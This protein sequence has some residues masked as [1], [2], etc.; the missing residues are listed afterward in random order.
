VPTDPNWSDVTLLIGCEGGSIVDESDNAVALTM[1]GATASSTQAKFGAYSAHVP[2][3]GFGFYSS[4]IPSLIGTTGPFTVE[5]FV[6][7]PSAIT[8]T[9]RLCCQLPTGT[10]AVRLWSVS[11]I[12]SSGTKLNLHVY[13]SGGTAHIF[14]S[15][16]LTFSTGTW[17]H[18][19]MDFDG[20]KYRGYFNG[21]RVAGVT[22]AYTMPSGNSQFSVGGQYDIDNN[23]IE[24]A[25]GDELYLDE[26]RIT[27]GVARYA[28]DTTY[29]IPAAAF[30]RDLSPVVAET[31]GITPDAA[32][33]VTFID[34]ISEI[35]GVAPA[36]VVS[37]TAVITSGIGISPLPSVVFAQ[38]AV[39]SDEIDVSPVL[40]AYYGAVVLERLKVN[41]SQ[42]PNFHSNLSVNDV[43][44][45]ADR[46][47]P[48]VPVAIAEG[49]GVALTDLA[50]QVTAVIEAL[51]LQDTL[52]P[53]LIYN[54][55][56]AETLRLA[57]TLARFFGADAVET[58]GIADVMSGTASMP[59]MLSETI[60]VAE[61]ASPQMVL[62]VV[63]SDEIDVNAAQALN[64]LFKPTLAD[65]IEI[66]A[67][68]L[69][70]GGG[71][72]TWAMNTRTGAVTEYQNYAF[73]SFARVGNKYI[74]ASSSGLY[75]LLGDDDDGTDIIATIRSGFAQWSGTHL[76]SFK[77]AYLAVRGAGA[78][79]LRV[80]TADGKTYN[81]SVT[82][83]S[84]KT[85]KVNMGRGL[86]ARY[87]AFELV[88][89]GQDFDLDT[90]EFIPLVADRRI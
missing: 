11:L 87:F 78:F 2:S 52:A 14:T 58:I 65:G 34:T 19:A 88:S 81:Y 61:A 69:S 66:S 13:D 25:T 7:A 37:L 67:A 43:A 28:S 17:Y 38:L 4:A 5:G 64:M 68:Y 29:T 16:A 77:A 79:V 8:M 50:Q 80:L 48:G 20:T 70:P 47:L 60:G 39:I 3:G 72:L 55:S 21:S 90:L 31:I 71:V 24:G 46:L 82:A 18:F 27:N 32:H 89:A 63:A 53:A 44:R 54:R 12:S 9:N 49:I 22:A 33:F 56:V 35:L 62:R 26:I 45:F 75:E 57:D 6:Y 36:T 10:G 59:G 40:S 85:A 51:R 76:G 83:E 15:S 23:D 42:V 73:N 1:D 84:M 30:P 74:G 86:R 41:L